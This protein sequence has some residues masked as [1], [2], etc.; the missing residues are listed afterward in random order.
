MTVAILTLHRGYR[1]VHCFGGKHITGVSGKFA[2]VC[3]S[4]QKVIA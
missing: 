4:S 2:M 1:V 3:W